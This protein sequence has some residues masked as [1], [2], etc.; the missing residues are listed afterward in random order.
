MKYKNLKIKTARILILGFFFLRKTVQIIEIQKVYDLHKS[1]CKEVSKVDI[2]D[3]LVNIPEA[4]KS[5][6]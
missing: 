5:C 1:P 3:P 6:L 4:K 2:Y